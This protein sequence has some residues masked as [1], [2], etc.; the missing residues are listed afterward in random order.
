MFARAALCHLLVK[1]GEAIDTGRFAALR[2]GE[3]GESSEYRV[4]NCLTSTALPIE[5]LPQVDSKWPGQD[6]L[7]YSCMIRYGPTH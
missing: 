7:R 5:Y 3:F 2:L 1:E 4:G 6:V